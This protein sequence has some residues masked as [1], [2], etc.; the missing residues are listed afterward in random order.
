MK[1]ICYF[2]IFGMLASSCQQER[3]VDYEA[4]KKSLI[5]LSETWSDLANTKDVD[6]LMF[7]WDEK[8]IMMAPGMP[9][10]RGKEEIRTYVEGFMELPGS[11]IEWE[12]IDV[13]ISEC[14]DMAY[15]IERNKVTVNDS[16]G[17]PM[18]T[19]NKVV[20]I[21]KKKED[22]SWKNVIDMWNE[23]PNGEF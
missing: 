17:T 3:K 15:L 7:G 1:A 23:D 5:S 9:P 18:T 6:T 14:G 20:T 16:L 11:H 4:E 10:L 13:H 8:A 22:G 21:W 12:P 2:L 19:Y